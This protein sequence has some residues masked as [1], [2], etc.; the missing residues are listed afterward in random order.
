[1]KWLHRPYASMMFLALLVGTP[2]AQAEQVTGKLL[3]APG[4]TQVEGSG[5]GGL[6]PWAVLA[7]YDS[8]EQTSGT[9]FSTQV[10]LP[11]YRL[12]SQGVA[13]SFYDRVEVSYA[14]HRFDLGTLGGALGVNDIEQDVLGVKAR[15]YGDLIYSQWPQ[16]SVGLQHRWLR[17]RAVAQVVGAD[18]A[19]QGTDLYVSA[20][21]LWLDAFSG[22]NVLG[23]LTLRA[24]RANQFGLLGYGG[25]V[26]K[27]HS[28]NAET[29]IALLPHPQWAIGAEYRQKP[30][31]LSAFEEEDA[32][33]VF[34]AYLPNEHF[35]VTGAWTNLGQ[36]A[37]S[38]EQKGFY[39]SLTGYLW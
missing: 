34:V 13:V 10:H 24:S 11:D 25:D 33:D 35:N 8:R 19:D 27:S 38:K 20:T 1:M 39:L 29:S 9:V 3:A 21:K 5:G 36:I 16:V 32:G 22:V 28:I 4:V 37:G 6:V 12:N 14:K 15:L 30:D 26:E 18:E 23:N 31:N 17:D 2:S 7:G